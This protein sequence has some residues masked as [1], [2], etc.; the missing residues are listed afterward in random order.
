MAKK[1]STKDVPWYY[2]GDEA[3]SALEKEVERQKKAKEDA[4]KMRRFYLPAEHKSRVTFVDGNVHPKGY[5]LPFAFMEHNLKLNGHWRN[6]FTCIGKGCPLCEH[7]NKPYLATVY[8]VIDHNKWTDKQGGI[9]ENEPRLF[10]AKTSAQ[11]ILKAKAEKKGGL[12]GWTVEVTRVKSESP[13]TGD[14]FD[15]EERNGFD[16]S[17]IE[18]ADYREIF[19][20]KSLE[21][22]QEIFSGSSGTVVSADDD[23]VQY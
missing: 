16:I 21:E 11:R 18:I 9:H 19:A 5:K 2:T 23:E 17:K 10:V 3:D 13:S 20:P 15:F 14:D 7:G 22:L 8:T 12:Q 1:E 4:G 6:W